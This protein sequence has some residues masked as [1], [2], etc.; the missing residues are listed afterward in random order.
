MRPMTCLWC[1]SYTRIICICSVL[2]NFWEWRISPQYEMYIVNSIPFS[3]PLAF[4]FILL[5]SFALFLSLSSFNAHLWIIENLYGLRVVDRDSRLH[6]KG[7]LSYLRI[8]VCMGKGENHVPLRFYCQS[9]VVGLP[10]PFSKGTCKLEP[11]ECLVAYKV[12]H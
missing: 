8:T 2:Y 1:G 5:S 10:R 3:F 4:L 7:L 11:M 12:S 6:E 9:V